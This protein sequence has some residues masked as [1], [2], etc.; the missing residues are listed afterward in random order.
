MALGRVW[1]HGEIMRDYLPRQAGIQQNFEDRLGASALSTISISVFELG[2]WKNA[3]SAV[4]SVGW[5]S[6]L[7][8]WHL[9]IQTTGFQTIWY[10]WTGAP[11]AL[12]NAL[13]AQLQW[14]REARAAQSHSEA[15]EWSSWSCGS[16]VPRT[17]GRRTSN[18]AMTQ[19]SVPWPGTN[20][21]RSCI[22][23][24]SFLMP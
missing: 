17:A 19:P 3:T 18:G 14:F 21:W 16:D 11:H 5:N 7:I 1:H 2:L 20:P 8:F 13:A 24:S 6:L 12:V 9:I 10:L 23:F 22:H 4:W 15:G